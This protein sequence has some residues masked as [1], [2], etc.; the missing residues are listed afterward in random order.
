MAY[1]GNI[2]MHGR[3]KENVLGTSHIWLDIKVAQLSVLLELQLRTSLLISQIPLGWA[4]VT[5]E[6]IIM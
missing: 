6:I 5:F 4:K 1:Y 3:I 2:A